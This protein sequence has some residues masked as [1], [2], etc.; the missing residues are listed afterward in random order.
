MT[1]FI[2]IDFEIHY[3]SNM[4]YLSDISLSH[5]HCQMQNHTPLNVLKNSASVRFHQGTKAHYLVL[6]DCSVEGGQGFGL[7]IE[8]DRLNHKHHS[9]ACCHEM[10]LQV[11]TLE[12]LPIVMDH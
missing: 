10:N 3:V 8:F 1:K 6:L 2:S 7:R 12:Q 4:A 11:C 5:I 9:R